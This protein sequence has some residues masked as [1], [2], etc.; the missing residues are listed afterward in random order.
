MHQ[1]QLRWIKITANSSIASAAEYAGSVD[2][3]L[4]HI[5]PAS[6]GTEH[7]LAPA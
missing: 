3:H 7:P 5:P 1:Q 6:Q 2:L 4:G